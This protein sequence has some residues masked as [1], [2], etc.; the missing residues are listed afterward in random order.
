MISRHIYTAISLPKI[1]SLF[2]R[3]R[4]KS[5]YVH[6]ELLFL[7]FMLLVSMLYTKV[8]QKTQDDILILERAQAIMLIDIFNQCN[9]LSSLLH[10]RHCF[11]WLSS[12]TAFPAVKSVRL[13]PMLLYTT[14]PWEIKRFV[15]FTCSSFRG[16]TLPLLKAII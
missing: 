12:K 10:K 4:Q 16:L 11:F 15:C 1:L 7:P 14:N 13:T 6:C 8:G 3:G 5:T 2:A 9:F